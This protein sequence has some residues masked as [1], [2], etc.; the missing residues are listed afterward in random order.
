M[1]GEAP[2]PMTAMVFVLSTSTPLLSAS[3][4]P[5]NAGEYAA[6]CLFLIIFAAWTRLLM[7]I[8]HILERE[9]WRRGPLQPDYHQY[10]GGGEDD[11][12]SHAQDHRDGPNSS[13]SKTTL[14]PPVKPASHFRVILIGL[15]GYWADTSV[16]LRLARAIF[17]M[18]IAGH[19]YLV[20]LAVMTMNVGYFVAVLTGV[21]L[22]TFLLATSAENSG[23]E[24][25]DDC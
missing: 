15:R 24:H 22:G 13:N 7:A 9:R 12:D 20:M 3:W 2:M 8:R 17:D 25:G 11:N 10:K 6:T 16:S 4:V 1:H 5:R 14:V 18:T 19:A 21:F 23:H